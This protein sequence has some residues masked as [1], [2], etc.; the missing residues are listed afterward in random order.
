MKSK[1]SQTRGRSA[2][3]LSPRPPCCRRRPRNQT[4]NSS[5]H[6]TET[7]SDHQSPI[8]KT[9]SISMPDDL[10]TANHHLPPDMYSVLLQRKRIV[11][12]ELNL[13]NR[14]LETLQP[15]RSPNEMDWEP[16]PPN[17]HKYCPPQQP[18][19]QQRPFDVSG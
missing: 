6:S 7:S 17:T 9:D 11:T 3:L 15:P 8:D 16:I 2:G 14:Y 13:L 18:H 5:T 12:E 19:S 1:I 10:Q 4:R